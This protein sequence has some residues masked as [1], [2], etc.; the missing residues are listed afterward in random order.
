[1]KTYEEMFAQATACKTKG[2]AEK[3]LENEIA[4]IMRMKP[5]LVHEQARQ[6]VLSNIG[7]MTGYGDRTE[8]KRLLE[9]FG[10]RHPIFGAIEDWPK[11]PEET[12]ELGLKFGMAA[13][14]RAVRR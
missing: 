9:L 4:I 10:A 7:Y 2:E 13:K 1:M 11:T 6:I 14:A 3:F 8:A 5:T 12:I